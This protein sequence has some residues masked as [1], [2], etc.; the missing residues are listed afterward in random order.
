[1]YSLLSNGSHH[2]GINVCTGGVFCC[3]HWSFLLLTLDLSY[4]TAPSCPSHLKIKTFPIVSVVVES[5]L[6]QSIHFCWTFSVPKSFFC[7]ISNNFPN[8]SCK[9]SRSQIVHCSSL[10]NTEMSLPI[11]CMEGLL[12]K[13]FHSVVIHSCTHPWNI[14]RKS[15]WNSVYY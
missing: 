7:F 10:N 14:D 8:K 15:M 6:L 9:Q 2:A 4:E 3:S 1:M 13:S 12:N 5:A 11:F